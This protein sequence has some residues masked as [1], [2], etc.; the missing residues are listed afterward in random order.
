MKIESAGF[1]H[2]FHAGFAGSLIALLAVAG[3]A[4]GD[5]VFPCRAAA[6]RARNHMI[7]RELARRHYR[8]AVLADVPVTQQNIFARERARLVRNAAI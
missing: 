8:T 5:Q 7:E 3:M 2:E 1:A 4:A 6:S